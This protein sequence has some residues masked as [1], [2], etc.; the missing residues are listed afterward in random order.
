MRASILA[1]VLCFT[2]TACMTAQDFDATKSSANA[3]A[4]QLEAQGKTEEAAKIRAAVSEADAEAT[5]KGNAVATGASA[6]APFIPYG[7]GAI[8]A[9]GLVE[10]GKAVARGMAAKKIAAAVKSNSGGAA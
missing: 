1:L 2:L 10:V 6:I 5:A 7:L 4:A 8:G 3:R 9:I